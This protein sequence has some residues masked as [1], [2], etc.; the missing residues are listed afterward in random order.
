MIQWTR[1][2]LLSSC[3]GPYPCVTKQQ[4]QSPATEARGHP[5]AGP[6]S[7]ANSCAH[8]GREGMGLKCKFSKLSAHIPANLTSF[9]NTSLLFL[10]SSLEVS[11]SAVLGF[12]E[13]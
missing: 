5:K 13:V 12:F 2:C 9:L 7:T 8:F 1:K 6:P 3:E 11:A 4:L 10:A